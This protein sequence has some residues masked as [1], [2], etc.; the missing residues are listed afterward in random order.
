MEVSFSDLKEKE[1]VNL[2]DG[3]KLG[4]IIDI[5]FDNTNGMVR[6]I[7]V[8]GEKKFFRKGE[9]LFVPLDRLRKIGDDVI[10]INLQVNSRAN[11][12]AQ[13]VGYG[14]NYYQNTIQREP[15]VQYQNIKGQSQSNNAS[16]VRFRPIDNKKYK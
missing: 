15:R 8:P 16:Y 14:L 7:V 1:I 13:N 2:N 11:Y 4:R 3:K 5:L 6:G 9:D 12:G 10:L